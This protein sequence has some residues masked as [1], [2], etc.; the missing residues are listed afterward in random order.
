MWW[1][2][3][4]YSSDVIVD[5]YDGATLLTTTSLSVDQTANAG[6]WNQLGAGAYTF[7]DTA[8]VVITVPSGGSA[9][10]D[11]IKFAST[12]YLY[13]IAGR[14][15][16]TTDQA[17]DDTTYAYDSLGRID[18]V[19]DPDSY[20]V[21]YDHDNLNRRT[22]LTYPDTAFITY[23]YDAMGRLT[24]I[25]DD[26]GTPVVIAHYD[27]DELSRRTDLYYN[28]DGDATYNETGQDSWTGYDYCDRTAT[29]TQADV[30]NWLEQIVN[31]IKNDGATTADIIFDY[32]YDAVGN[33]LN[34]VQSSL[35]N[36][37]AGTAIGDMTSN[38]G[39][40]NAFDDL[41]NNVAGSAARSASTG[42]VGKNWGAS[43]K[44]IISKF[45]IKGPSDGTFGGLS[46]DT[47]DIELY[48]SD[49]LGVSDELL[50]SETGLSQPANN[51][52]IT[53]DAGI[54]I[55]TSYQYHYVEI[56]ISGAS[57]VQIAEVQFYGDHSLHSYDNI[58]QLT[59]LDYSDST[60]IDFVYDSLGNWSTVNDNGTT[61]TYLTTGNDLNQYDQSGV[62]SP[63]NDNVYTYDDNGN[64]TSI[65]TDGSPGDEVTYTYDSENRLISVDSGSTTTYTYD[66]AGRRVSKTDSSD[67]VT[68]YVYDGDQVIAEYDDHTT[69]DT[70]VLV[71]KFI[72][73]PGIDEP[74]CMI[75]PAGQ[76]NAGT[77]FYH[78]DGLGSVV[79]LSN[80]S[81]II[82]A[83]YSYD[84]LK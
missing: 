60:Y 64:L 80:T 54:D 82:E 24:D 70:F 40:A 19:T 1:S 66:H 32:T 59:D 30:G 39:V 79:A 48:G 11:A 46:T 4:S 53:I 28:L 34:T 25:K 73:G 20:I 45:T 44:R 61:T 57:Q 15:T 69:P 10:A 26:G 12:Q 51:G 8:K 41:V 52:V 27:Y 42:Y 49:E 9:C 5:I 58:Y 17:G 68:K 23:H 3:T 6:Q 43:Q 67:I 47:V 55:S 78:F 29:P 35:I 75:I 50:Y 22:K 16:E 81:G 76:T 18:T 62:N 65:N 72:Y 77:Y 21:E 2:D 7:S 33:R 63:Y 13:D 84:A 31:D 74:I 71:R 83:S 38:G 14:I 36:R 37:T 56:T